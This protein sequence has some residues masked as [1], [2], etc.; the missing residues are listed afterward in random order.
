VRSPVTNPRSIRVAQSLLGLASNR[1]EQLQVDYQ[2]RVEAMKAGGCPEAGQRHLAN[3]IGVSQ[4]RLSR[5]LT[6]KLKLA[7]VKHEVNE[8]VSAWLETPFAAP[9]VAEAEESAAAADV[10]CAPPP[11]APAASAATLAPRAPA[12]SALNRHEQLQVAYEK[13]VEAMKAGGC[14]ETG[15]RHLA[16]L[17]GVSQAMLSRWL[18]GT[19]PKHEVDELVS[20]W[21]ETPFAAPVVAEAEESGSLVT[22]LVMGVGKARLVAVEKHVERAAAVETGSTSAAPAASASSS[23]SAST[24]VSASAAAHMPLAG[25]TR[26]RTSTVLGSSDQATVANVPAVNK[27][28]HTTAATNHHDFMLIGARVLKLVRHHGVGAGLVA[29]QYLV[30]GIDSVQGSSTY[31]VED[32]QGK[33]VKT[34]LVPR[35]RRKDDQPLER[36][37]EWQMLPHQPS[38]V[39]LHPTAF[40]CV[41]CRLQ[42]SHKPCVSCYGSLDVHNEHVLLSGKHFGELASAQGPADPSAPPP[43]APA[44]PAALAPRASDVV[45]CDDNDNDMYPTSGASQPPAAAPTSVSTSAAPAASASSSASSSTFVSASATTPSAPPPTRMAAAMLGVDDA[46]VDTSPMEVTES[47][48]TAAAKMP[49]ADQRYNTRKRT[50]TVLGSSDQATAAKVHKPADPQGLPLRWTSAPP[51]AAPAASA[52]VRATAAA[53][54]AAVEPLEGSGVETEPDDEGFPH[55]AKAAEEAN[56]ANAAKEAKEATPAA[57]VVKPSWRTYPHLPTYLP[58]NLP[59]YLPTYLPTYQ[60]TYLPTYPRPHPHPHPQSDDVW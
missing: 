32:L 3:L 31:D 48:H 20:S 33:E 36:Q 9:V 42:S 5:W 22:R 25:Q 39:P 10:T 45:D 1:H 53:A 26:K 34:D 11:A 50:S 14:P 40:F 28:H 18:T 6:G 49:P 2:K 30:V 52:A 51:P 54:A 19:S 17:I 46:L 15:Q 60:P 41:Q 58:T 12:A 23:A 21:L 13:R 47:A 4:A 55:P 43:T 35:M 59:S 8:L 29:T 56:A 38:I 44:A 37:G 24:F 7:E 27:R 57:R 16:T